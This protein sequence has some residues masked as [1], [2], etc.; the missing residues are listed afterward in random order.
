MDNWVRAGNHW[1]EPNMIVIIQLANDGKERGHVQP[2]FLKDTQAWKQPY[3]R[4]NPPHVSIN[5][6]VLGKQ[7][8]D[9]DYDK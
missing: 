5:N 1:T 8:I 7:M 6:Q 2:I 4:D 3:D 9:S